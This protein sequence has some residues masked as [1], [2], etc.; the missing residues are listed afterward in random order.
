MTRHAKQKE[1]TA[2]IAY[3]GARKVKGRKK[4][5]DAREFDLSK[6]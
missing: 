4:Y 1:S 3:N 5:V 2:Y 6:W